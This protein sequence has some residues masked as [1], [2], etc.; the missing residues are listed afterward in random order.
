MR[1]QHMRNEGLSVHISINN[2]KSFENIHHYREQIKK[3]KDSEDMSL[4]LVPQGLK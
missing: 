4:V 3:V 1:N 2:P